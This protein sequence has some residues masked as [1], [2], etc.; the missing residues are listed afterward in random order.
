MLGSDIKK[1]WHNLRTTFSR[2]YKC[3][4]EGKSGDSGELFFE[5]KW[6]HFKRMLFLK[7]TMNRDVSTSSIDENSIINENSECS[8]SSQSTSSNDTSTPQ[9]HKS[10]K[11]IK[12][13]SE[14]D[15]SELLEM[16]SKLLSTG[17]D[18]DYLWA[19][20]LSLRL[21]RF[22]LETKDLIKLKIDEIILE[23]QRSENINNQTNDYH[24]TTL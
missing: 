14:N 23:F 17:E 22:P 10:S 8:L 24:L 5:P 20:S 3:L 11:R 9:D 18:E 21:K 13:R 2:N 15:R 4:Q 16:A 19:K 7:D 6:Q 1:K 12:K